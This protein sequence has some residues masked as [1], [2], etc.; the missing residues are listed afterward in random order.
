MIILVHG[1][2]TIHQ[3]SQEE[4]EARKHVIGELTEISEGVFTSHW[5]KRDELPVAETRAPRS[6]PGKSKPVQEG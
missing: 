5:V 2:N 4:Y 6:K 3:F 1:E